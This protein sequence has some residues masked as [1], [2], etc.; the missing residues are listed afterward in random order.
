MV[1]SKIA[2]KYRQAKSKLNEAKEGIISNLIDNERNIEDSNDDE[3]DVKKTKENKKYS[4]L[5]SAGLAITT[6][7]IGIVGLTGGLAAPFVFAALALEIVTAAFDINRIVKERRKERKN[8]QEKNR[9]EKTSE[10]VKS[11]TKENSLTTEKSVG[12]T[13]MSLSSDEDSI[14]NSNKKNKPYPLS[15]LNKLKGNENP[16]APKFKIKYSK[17]TSTSNKRDTSLSL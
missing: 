7:A 16:K 14:N 11:V 1:L 13:T 15:W 12:D 8:D 2:K 17:N 10:L 4:N 5:F 6:V 9:A 3:S